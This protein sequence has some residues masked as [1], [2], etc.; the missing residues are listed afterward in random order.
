MAS[1]I[2]SP[3]T[4]QKASTRVKST[5]PSPPTSTTKQEEREY[6]K[7]RLA[8]A[9]RIFAKHGF[10]EG[11]AGHITVRDPISPATFWVNPFGV[12]FSQI[13]PEDLIQVNHEGKVIAGGKDG[14]RHLNSAAFMIHGAIHR[15]R[16]DVLCAAH[17]HSIYG[18]AF[19]ALGRELDIISQDAC[20]FWNDHVVYRQFNGVVLAEEEGENIAAALGPK[21]AALLQNHGLLTVGQSI[22]EAVYWFTSLEKCC[23]E[24]LLA[25]AAAAGRRGETVKIDD[26]AAEFTFRTV[27]SPRGG[28]F[29]G[30]PLFDVAE[31]EV[32]RENALKN[33]SWA[34]S[35]SHNVVDVVLSAAL[36]ALVGVFALRF[37]R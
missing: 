15:A 22:E 36:G 26:V 28:W 32:K 37:F 6:L 2:N 27:V 24:Q 33:G 1:T 18:R 12:A 25:D 14:R 30:M 35:G 20:S 7:T 5:I 29:A 23:Q 10:E 11:V 34:V 16:P 17:S 4:A 13:T 8:L 31:E 9:F 19:C 21:K 3:K